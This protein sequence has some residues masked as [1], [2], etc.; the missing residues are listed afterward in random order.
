MVMPLVVRILP[1]FAYCS[2]GFKFKVPEEGATLGELGIL[3]F[4]KKY[5][6]GQSTGF[7]R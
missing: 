6:L 5:T 3:G 4:Q 1:G 7:S 2:M